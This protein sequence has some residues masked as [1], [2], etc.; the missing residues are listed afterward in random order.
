MIAQS[1]CYRL[2]PK[3]VLCC[4]ASVAKSVLAEKVSFRD[5]SSLKIVTFLFLQSHWAAEIQRQ[6]AKVLSAYALV[7]R[8]IWHRCYHFKGGNWAVQ[9]GQN[10]YHQAEPL[11]GERI[12]IIEKAFHWSKAYTLKSLSAKFGIR[13]IKGHQTLT[14]RRRKK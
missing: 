2:P 8:T 7:E 6:L 14:E 12:E 5:D 13:P 10:G 11:R 9:R 3:P 1:L 4:I